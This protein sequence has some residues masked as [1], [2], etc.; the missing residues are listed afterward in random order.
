MVD[1]EDE[2]LADG[3]S[4][5]SDTSTSDGDSAPAKASVAVAE[6]TS[7]AKGKGWRLELSISLRGVLV[8]VALALA[9]AA[10]AVLAVLDV[11]AHHE[12][13]AI[14]QRDA[15]KAHAEEVGL[16]YAV[17]AAQVDY[18]HLDAWK[19]KVVQ[20]ASPEL[21]EKLGKA[22]EQMTQLLGPLQ[23]HSMA[24]PLAAKVRSDSNGVYVVDCFVS[25]LTETVQSK[26]PLQSTATYVVTLDKAK[27]W[28]VT[29]VGGLGA[30][31]GG[32]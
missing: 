29:D 7:G 14:H 13:S 8:A 27:N 12:L 18:K 21:T 26:D 5:E 4:D 19:A 6:A 2:D 3:Q 31:V 25:V 15:D 23:W 22:A 24:H 11:S 32:N 9:S 20:G 17:N 1:G 16:E 28:A 30:I 10:V